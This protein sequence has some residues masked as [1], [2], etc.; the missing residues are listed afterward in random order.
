LRY[1][2]ATRKELSFE[3]PGAEIA[4]HFYPWLQ[5][6]GWTGVNKVTCR[7]LLPR[8]FGTHEASQ[9]ARRG[10]IE[11]CEGARNTARRLALVAM[12]CDLTFADMRAVR[13]GIG[14]ELRK[15]YSDVLREE[16]PD[17][18]A[19]LLRQFDRQ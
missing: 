18:M 17:E 5:R 16:I 12:A 14:A 9:E 15:L 4:P 11:N 10:R 7:G 6:Y 8:A 13:T 3:R 19:E 2:E 1:V